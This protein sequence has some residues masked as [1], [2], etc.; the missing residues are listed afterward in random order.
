MTMNVD[1]APVQETFP[2]SYAE[3]MCCACDG[4]VKLSFEDSILLA[5]DNAVRCPLCNVSVKA[6][7]YDQVCLSNVHKSLSNRGRF[8][9]PFAVVWFSA[10][11]IVALFVN[12]QASVVMTSVG[13]LISYA[14]N[15]NTPVIDNV[16]SLE[17]AIE[18]VVS[19]DA[20]Q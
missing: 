15:K 7:L 12:T 13:L 11:F 1:Q 20:V 6:K 17:R 3:F 19:L 18:E 16:I 10:S 4:H 5:D 14:L 8:I 2:F 9:I